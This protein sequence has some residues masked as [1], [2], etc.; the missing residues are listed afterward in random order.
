[1]PQAETYLVG[2]LINI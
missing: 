2:A 1:M